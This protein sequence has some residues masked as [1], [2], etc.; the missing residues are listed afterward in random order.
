M[1]LIIIIIHCVSVMKRKYTNNN[2][3]N[4]TVIQHKLLFFVLYKDYI[5]KLQWT[6]KQIAKRKKVQ[7]REK[8]RKRG[9]ILYICV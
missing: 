6:I 1:K 4:I 7:E 9:R 2:R 5:N 3:I 8:E